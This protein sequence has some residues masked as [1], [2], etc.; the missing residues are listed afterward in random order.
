MK[1]IHIDYYFSFHFKHL[2]MV[3]FFFFLSTKFNSLEIRVTHIIL[4]NFVKCFEK[5]NNALKIG[6]MISVLC[7][8]LFNK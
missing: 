3:R 8:G 2:S 4:S 1:K 6:N 7:L 5:Y